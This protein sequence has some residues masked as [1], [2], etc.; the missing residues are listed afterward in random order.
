MFCSSCGAEVTGA[1]CTRCGARASRPP[2]PSAPP[3]PPVQ[4]AP[5][6]QYVQPPA[7][8][9]KSG[10]G[11]K[12]LFAVLAILGLLGVFAIAGIWYAVHTVKQK[13][14]QVAAS[15]GIDL[16]AITETHRGPV[17]T[18]DAC[19]LLT[20]EDLSQILSLPVERAEG[21]G[22]S[23]TSSCEY[24]SSQ[25]QQ[26]GEQEASAA[27]KKMEGHKTNDNAAEQAQGVRDF[28]DL[29]RGITGAAGATNNAPILTISIDSETPGA[30]VAGFKTG[31]GLGLADSLMKRMGGAPNLVTEN[32]PGVG[33]EGVFAPMLGWSVFRKGDVAVI[34]GARMLPGGREAQIAIAKRIFS[35]L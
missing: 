16:G 29:V 28:G 34:I 23:A 32:V 8:A 15:Q 14:K 17:R 10:G 21:S 5:P 30:V 4:Y 25:A 6:A 33:D 24:Y 18:F 9:A 31:S 26:R 13:V 27:A 22:K 2:S 11:L 3:P 12:I 1:F 7:A 35:K 20:K 19:A